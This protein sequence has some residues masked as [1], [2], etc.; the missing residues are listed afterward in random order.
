MKSA[1]VLGLVLLAPQV[2]LA[3]AR[4][5]ATGALI[6]DEHSCGTTTEPYPVAVS[7]FVAPPP[8]AT[9][10]VRTVFLNGK[11]GTYNIT[12]GAT[13]AATNT[14]STIASGNGRTHMGAVIPPVEA[15]F[16]W[17]YV[18]AC[19]KKHYEPYNIVITET[20]P[21]SGS[22]IE[23][24]VGGNGSSTGWS[25]GSGILGVA[26]AD[27]FCGVTEKG[28]AFTF[29][30]NHLGISKPNDELCATIAHEIGHL[31]ALEHEVAAVDTMSYVPFASSMKKSF[32]NEN[33]A[34]GTTPSAPRSCSCPTTGTGQVTSSGVK[35]TQF[36][37]LRPMEKVAPE[38]SIMSPDDKATV[39]PAFTVT[40]TASDDTAM[41]QVLVLLDGVERG[42]SV[43]PEGTTYTI[44]LDSVAEGPHV[45]EVQAIDLA[46]NVTTQK[47]D[48]TV[49][50]GALGETC[51]ANRDC[52]G[53]M[54]AVTGE[55][56]FCTQ[57]CGDG[58][59]CPDD[60]AC[61]DAGGQQ[62]CVPSEG[63]GCSAAGSSP[64]AGGLLGLLA[65]VMISFRRRRAA[66]R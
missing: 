38:L 1:V 4:V 6:R 51:S 13:N 64:G 9:P 16:N 17:P 52:K 40:A 15:S 2:A 65:V 7:S 59:G 49:A 14:A 53:N 24:V 29:S 43:A 39:R 60:F 55:D 66:A 26:A 25:T 37:G 23:A 34:C 35:L 63:G 20:E 12:S 8:A 28:I 18:V 3:G 11:G 10:T 32:T 36:L 41:A 5:D 22:Y 62:V 54:C 61:A 27:N 48:I 50:F 45:L 31:L 30:T 33:A 42:T 21:T 19:V 56:S 44:V 47:R 46:G 57:T 58:M